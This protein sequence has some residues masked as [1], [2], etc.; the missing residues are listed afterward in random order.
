TNKTCE[1]RQIFLATAAGA[2]GRFCKTGEYRRSWQIAWANRCPQ[3]DRRVARAGCESFAIG[4]PCDGPDVVGVTAQADDL[5]EC[6]RVPDV[7]ELIDAAGHDAAAVRRE[8]DVI[9]R[10]AVVA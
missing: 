3:P 8:R 4:T 2:F 6:G 7:D 1:T 9:N 10:A 5:L